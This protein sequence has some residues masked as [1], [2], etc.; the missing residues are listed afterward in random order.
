MVDL[1]IYLNSL[2]YHYD[3]LLTTLQVLKAYYGINGLGTSV[4][5]FRIINVDI[6]WSIMVM[7][8]LT[9]MYAKS[10]LMTQ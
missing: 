3:K 5:I 9:V 2:I 6:Y 7:N 8:D 1:S 4:A 10:A